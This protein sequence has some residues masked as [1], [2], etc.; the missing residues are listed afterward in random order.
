MF[1]AAQGNQRRLGDYVVR[2]EG[3]DTVMYTGLQVA[4]DP[5]VPVVWAGC[6]LITLGCLAAFFASHRRVWARVRADAKGTHVFIGG[7]A[8]RNRISF[9]K[10][11][12]DLCQHA[13]EIFEK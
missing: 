7:N 2:L 6:T 9:E 4:K 8:S 3:V 5:G 1:E 12:A 11:F 10:Q 13:Q